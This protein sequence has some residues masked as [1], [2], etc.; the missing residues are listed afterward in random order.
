MIVFQAD[1]T[2]I[3]LDYVPDQI[4]H[5]NQQMSIIQKIMKGRVIILVHY[6]SQQWHLSRCEVSSWYIYYTCISNTFELCCGHVGWP[7]KNY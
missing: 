5:E 7:D 1:S 4:K 3:I 2:N 6:T